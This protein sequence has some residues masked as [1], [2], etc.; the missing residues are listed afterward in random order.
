[1]RA[2]PLWA[3]AAPLLVAAAGCAAHADAPWPPP[4]DPVAHVWVV[5]HGWHTRIAVRCADV[6]PATWPEIRDLGDVA[7]VEVGWGDRD[8]YPEPEPSIWDALDPVVRPTPAALYVAGFDLPPPQFLP[9]AEMVRLP[10]APAGLDGLARF[11][12]EHYVRGPAGEPVRIRPGDH[13]PSWYYQARGRYHVLRNSN[14]W[15]ARALAAAGVPT[16][17]ALALT[18][19]LLMYQLRRLAERAPDSADWRRTGSAGWRTTGKQAA[20]AASDRRGSGLVEAS[21]FEP[22][23]PALRTPCS[24]N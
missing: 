23:T 1:M 13:E 22:P 9:G 19:S 24:P 18:A 15:T 17:P 16:R 11:V 6:D 14:A 12:H 2:R 21:G 3:L 5:R 10:V 7:Y 20:G 4:P 8:F